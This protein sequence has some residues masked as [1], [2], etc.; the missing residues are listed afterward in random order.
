M[1]TH[2]LF[3]LRLVLII[4]I[5]ALTTFVHAQQ[6]VRVDLAN[7]GPSNGVAIT[8]VWVGFHDGSFDSYDAGLSS[9]PGLERLA[10]DGDTSL[11]STDF[12]AGS[13]YVDNS[14]GTPVSATVASSQ[15]G[16]QRVD[17]TIGSPTGPPPL[18]PGQSAFGE[19]IVATDGSNSFFSYASMILPTSDY[20][21]A[22]GNPLAF[23]L[24]DL[25]DGTVSA[26]EFNIGLPGTINDAGTEVNDFA[27]S[28]ANGLFPGRGL[29]TGQTA[30]DQGTV[31]GG[32]VTN[33]ANAFSGFANSA[34]VDL[35]GFDFNNASLYP[36]GIATIRITAVPEPSSMTAIALGLAGIGLRRRR[37]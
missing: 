13:T 33:V 36:N 8:P 16:S 2:L 18:L 37:L 35:A 17:G 20:F 6:R 3:A 7:N 15:P 12:I 21:V 28:P 22:N 4:T 32:A 5:C 31:E 9:Q 23:N 10:E 1:Q 26:I 25:F 29:P 19:F 14:G 30:P 24:D 11:I 34:G 27:D